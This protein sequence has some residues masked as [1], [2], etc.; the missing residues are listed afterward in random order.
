MVMQIVVGHG[1]QKLA[2][3]CVPCL[4]SVEPDDALERCR[5]QVANRRLQDNGKPFGRHR[6]RGFACVLVSGTVLPRL[7][8]AGAFTQQR[9]LELIAQGLASTLGTTKALRAG[10]ATRETRRPVF[11][12]RSADACG[13]APADGCVAL[14]AAIRTPR[15]PRFDNPGHP[16]GWPCPSACGKGDALV[17]PRGSAFCALMTECGQVRPKAAGP[18]RRHGGTRWKT[19]CR[20]HLE[21]ETDQ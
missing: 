19:S 11:S 21:R 14:R 18:G 12:R 7:I 3:G 2:S 20:G 8:V 6:H 15:G 1:F 16:P 17:I 4:L 9:E 13:R 10:R 5:Q